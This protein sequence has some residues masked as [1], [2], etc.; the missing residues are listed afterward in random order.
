M[1]LKEKLKNLFKKK[2]IYNIHYHIN[3]ERYKN[4]KSLKDL[5]KE[6][7]DRFYHIDKITELANN[8]NVTITATYANSIINSARIY[9]YVRKE[10]DKEFFIKVIDT[11]FRNE[12]IIDDISD[13]IAIEG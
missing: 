6:D 2:L 4:V 7:L 12:I 10:I 9:F 8:L 11:E 1:S 13:K 3:N 5:S